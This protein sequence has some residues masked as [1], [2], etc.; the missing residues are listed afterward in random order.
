ML[1]KDLKDGMLIRISDEQFCAW[2][3]TNN[4]HLLRND[5]PD[6]P[7]RLRIGSLVVGVLSAETQYA[8][9]DALVYVG[10]KIL[11]SHDGSKTRQVRMVLAGG[12]VAFVEGYDV[13]YF[14]PVA[15]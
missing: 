15:L 10:K 8:K 12:Q 11:K 9:N 2:L 13:K 5:W 1:C 3:D 7:P 6:I 14:E 4:F